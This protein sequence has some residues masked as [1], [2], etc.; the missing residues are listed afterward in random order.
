LRKTTEQALELPPDTPAPGIITIE[1]PIEGIASMAE[2]SIL[3][4]V[5]WVEVMIIIEEAME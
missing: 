5:V 4:G 2:T 3:S 1:E